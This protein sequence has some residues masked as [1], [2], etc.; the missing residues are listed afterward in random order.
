MTAVVHVD[1]QF[2]ASRAGGEPVTITGTDLDQVTS[3]SFG[4]FDGVISHQ[5]ADQLV[6]TAPDYR[7]GHGGSHGEVV[8][9][10][11]TQPTHT[12][13]VWTWEGKSLDEL[14]GPIDDIDRAVAF[15]SVQGQGAPHDAVDEVLQQP[16]PD[17]TGAAAGYAFVDGFTPT[18]VPRAGAWVTIS[19]RGFTGATRV[20]FGDFPVAEYRV[21]SDHQIV[22]L[23]PRYGAW[24]IGDGSTLPASPFVWHGDVMSAAGALPEVEWQLDEDVTITFEPKDDEPT[25][26][27]G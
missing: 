20:T 2:S 5:T 12:G 7:P 27:A 10:V 3:V 16:G 1:P 9:W 6:V 22:A 25:L 18:V 14:G 19:G 21:D 11:D 4:P 26:P 13:V 15:G 23:V 8:I 24:H 17:A